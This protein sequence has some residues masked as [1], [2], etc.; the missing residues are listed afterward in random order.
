MVTVA[1]DPWISVIVERVVKHF[2]PDRI[3]LFGSRARGDAR[4]D[5]DYDLLVVLPVVRSR[6]HDAVAIRRV[7]ADLPL[8]KDVIVAS[9]DMVETGGRL[10]SVLRPA[11]AEGTVIYERA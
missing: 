1:T 9:P 7:L 2:H 11:L 10:G 5:S 8:S 3:I 4:D 6:F